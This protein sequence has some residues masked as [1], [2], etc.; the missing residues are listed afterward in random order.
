MHQKSHTSPCAGRSHRGMICVGWRLCYLLAYFL[1]LWAANLSRSSAGRGLQSSGVVADSDNNSRR[2]EK[3][4]RTSPQD[5]R[6]TI[7]NN[8]RIALIFFYVFLERKCFIFC[9]NRWLEEKQ[10][11]E[12]V[13]NLNDFCPYMVNITQFPFRKESTSKRMI[14][15]RSFISLRPLPRSDVAASSQRWIRCRAVCVPP[16]DMLWAKPVPNQPSRSFHTLE[17]LKAA[18]RVCQKATR[19]Q[20]SQPVVNQALLTQ[21]TKPDLWCRVSSNLQKPSLARNFLVC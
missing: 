9:E 11:E 4:T 6:I 5:K 14:Y 13:R 12:D 17:C 19:K 3:T 8:K 20:T 21:Q 1:Y 10:E 18:Q 2:K 7:K 16:R 15:S